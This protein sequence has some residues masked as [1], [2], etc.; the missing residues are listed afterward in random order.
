MR[1]RILLAGVLALSLSACKKSFIELVPKTTVTEATFFRTADD[2]TQAVV[3]SYVPLRSITNDAYVMGEMR[4]DN[5]TY[6]ASPGLQGGQFSDKWNISGFLDIAINMNG[7]NKYASCYVGIA[8]TN[9]ILDR[10]DAS[11]IDAAVKANLKGQA[12][13]L[14][15]YYYFELVQYFGGVPLHLKEV[16][17]VA[18]TALPRSSADDVYKQ[19]IAD[20][21]S[22]ASLLPAKQT[23]LGM[24]TQG[25]AK[26]LLGYVYMTLKRYPEAETA[27]TDVTKLGYSLVPNYANIF[28][29]RNTAES[30]FEVQYLEG[31]QGQQGNFA[32][33]FAPNISNVK[34]ILGPSG[35]NKT[36]GGWNKPTPNLIA[37]YET[38]DTRKNASIGFSYID[39]DGNTVTDTYCKKYT[40]GPYANFNN[41]G[42]DWI[43]YRYADVLL[44]LAECL[45]EQG[46]AGQAIPYLN[47][48]RS[49][50]G[51]AATIAANQADLRVA[52]AKERRVELA[53]ENHRWLDLV[54]TGQAISVMTAFGA[55]I[56][57]QQPYLPANAY[58]NIT[59]NRLIFPLPQSELDINKQL[60]QNPG[61]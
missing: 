51:L 7:T 36:T 33:Q 27:L 61:Y 43:I 58:T 60:T 53:F 29:S 40:H 5:A 17:S 47:Q 52:I 38:G 12:Q 41:T 25:S 34:N 32:F 4:S 2:Y 11:T 39:G 1:T 57:T 19:I 3:G 21:T 18:E 54:R 48:V 35:D 30:I 9:A 55:T 31:P 26:T 37:A 15:A 59:Q 13:F 50:A 6:F 23:T 44:L 10:I 22:A 42:D 8:R 14:R 46:K 45:N 28:A 49:R 56:K 20:A 16:S 24:V